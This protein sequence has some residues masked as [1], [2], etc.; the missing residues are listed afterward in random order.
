MRTACF[1]HYVGKALIGGLAE[2]LVERLVERLVE[3]LVELL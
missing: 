3:L 1:I 2:H